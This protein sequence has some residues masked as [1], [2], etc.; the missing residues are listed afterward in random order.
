MV[1]NFRFLNVPQKRITR[2]KIVTFIQDKETKRINFESSHSH[3]LFR[4]DGQYV[5]TIKLPFT[6]TIGTIIHNKFSATLFESKFEEHKYYWSIKTEDEYS[7]FEEFVNEYKDI[8]FL[9]DHLDLSLALSMNY[10]GDERTEIGELEYQAKF[11]N[12]EEAES[13]LIEECED[14]LN[15]L[16]YYKDVDYI[17]A[18]PSSNPAEESLP[19]RIV[20]SLDDYED[21]SENV[22]WTSKTRS[23]KDAENAEIKLEILEESGLQISDIDLKGKTI[24][25]FDD[26]YMSG[27]SMQF[28]AM[29]LKEAGASHV[30]G[31]C[32]V[33]S[34]SNTTR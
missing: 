25:L 4:R 9:R 29:K 34:R 16:P 15:K 14:W 8:V 5:G 19:H 17:C 33:K 3:A 27:V 12:D 18:M 22:T 2:E 11:H 1:F 32:I 21:I 23:I 31:L 26:L 10:E 24:L 13:T 28:V 6:D 20:T 30:F 7:L